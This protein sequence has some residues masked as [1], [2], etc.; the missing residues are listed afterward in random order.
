MTLF[1]H[2]T[3]D[4]P[5]FSKYLQED[6]A[7]G[8][9]QKMANK[10]EPLVK[11]VKAAVEHGKWQ[12]DHQL[13]KLL[14]YAVEKEEK[15]S[16]K[17]KQKSHHLKSTFRNQVMSYMEKKLD[18]DPNDQEMK[19]ALA[20]RYMG[21]QN[22]I[23]ALSL[24]QSAHKEIDSSSIS[25]KKVKEKIG[26]CEKKVE[27]EAKSIGKIAK[28]I[29]LSK[30]LTQLSKNKISKK[31]VKI[32]EESKELLPVEVALI[33]LYTAEFYTMIN[34]HLRDSGKLEDYL[35]KKHVSRKDREQIISFIEKS[36]PIIKYS[37]KKMPSLKDLHPNDIS[38]R[39]VFRGMSVS[40]EYIQ[41]LQKDRKVINSG[42]TSTSTDP[43]AALHFSSY[44]KAKNKENQP[45]LLSIVD[46]KGNGVPIHKLSHFKD[47]DEVLFCPGADFK[48]KAIQK[49]T[50]NHPLAALVPDS[51]KHLVGKLWVASVAT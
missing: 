40:S 24:L 43:E 23:S 13:K 46:K 25:P 10:G 30:E 3:T 2:I 34:L 1:S 22:H 29:G 15:L 48:V 28:K 11:F 19:Y 7:K 26:K 32:L 49:I 8:C 17:L 5:R 16:K 41:N 9:I 44:S 27:K 47:E 45:L 39:I 12:Q 51:Y 6:T 38:K 20:K 42:F 37:V 35:K 36:I 4:L 21:K 14:D 33:R 18:S 50:S 31:I